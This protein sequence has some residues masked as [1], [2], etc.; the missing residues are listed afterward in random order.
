MPVARS[1]EDLVAL[2]PPQNLKL[3]VEKNE[4]AAKFAVNKLLI[5]Y[6][7]LILILIFIISS[8]SKHAAYF[9]RFNQIIR[10]LTGAGKEWVLESFGR[11][12]A[13]ESRTTFYR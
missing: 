4:I 13:R 3:I 12:L 7:T 6:Q 10:C 9:C 11:P 5:I 1:Y 8:F 2:N